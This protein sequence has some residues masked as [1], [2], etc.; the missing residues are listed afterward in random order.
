MNSKNPGSW[1]ADRVLAKEEIINWLAQATS[2]AHSRSII[3][4]QITESFALLEATGN[5]TKSITAK[6]KILTALRA[7]TRRDIGTSQIATFLGVGTS[8]FEAI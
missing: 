6:P 8:M 7:L 4:A 1:E 2:T 5:L 3:E